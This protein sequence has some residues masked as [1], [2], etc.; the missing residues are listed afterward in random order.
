MIKVVLVIHWLHFIPLL[1][2]KGLDVVGVE[3]LAVAVVRLLPSGGRRAELHSCCSWCTNLCEVGLHC[4]AESQ[5]SELLGSSPREQGREQKM[6]PPRGRKGLPSRGSRQRAQQKQASEACQ[7]CP[8]YVI[9]PWSIPA[10][11][12]LIMYLHIVLYYIMLYYV[13]IILYMLT[14]WPYSRG[15]IL[16]ILH[17]TIILLCCIQWG[18][19][20]WGYIHFW[21][22]TALWSLIP[23]LIQHSLIQFIIGGL[24]I[25]EPCV[26]G[27]KL[28]TAVDLREW[29]WPSLSIMFVFFLSA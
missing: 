22:S 21:S 6:S 19:R 10:N 12:I 2:D 20:G 16:S 15:I 14:T 17:Y 1:S 13:L 5:E 11:T 23:A 26:S 3:S 27:N 7:C 28:S 18:E 4:R 8:S 9:C 29:G 25:L 24:W